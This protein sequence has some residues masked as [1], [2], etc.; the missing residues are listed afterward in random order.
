VASQ[1]FSGPEKRTKQ[2]VDA[3]MR[4]IHKQF[5]E[6]IHVR[7]TN[8]V[9]VSLYLYTSLTMFYALYHLLLTIES[10]AYT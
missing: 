6:I 5:S 4:S 2:D 7:P 9:Y 8:V 1:Y 10:P 3:S